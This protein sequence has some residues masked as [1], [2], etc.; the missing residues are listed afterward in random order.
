MGA[1][2]SGFHAI[3]RLGEVCVVGREAERQFFLELLDRHGAVVLATLRR[4]CRSSHDAEDVFQ[5]TAM[6]VWRYLPRRNR[7]RAPRAWLMT[8]AYRSYLDHRS[9]SP[10]HV[11]LR[12]D[13]DETF[14]GPAQQ[15]QRSEERQRV[16]TAVAGL[17]GAI[18]EVIVL[19]YTGG[20]TLRQTAKAM[21][22]SLGTA[23]S[24]LNNGLDRLRKAM[25]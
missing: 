13:P 2:H 23:K 22:I 3:D 1:M 8:V 18:H 4:L 16:Q 11:E 21:G 25:S 5:E 19:H 15:A 6:R 10:T 20:L 7:L 14:P 17:P 24:R 12:D 9:R